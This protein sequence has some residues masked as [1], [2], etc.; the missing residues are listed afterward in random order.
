MQV[1]IPAALE[2]FVRSKVATGEFPSADEVISE[3]LRL[4]QSDD[5]WKKEARRK[6]DNAWEQARSGQMIPSEEAWADLAARK[7]EWLRNRSSK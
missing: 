5:Q 3:G 1:T 4:L 2:E 6:I 7:E